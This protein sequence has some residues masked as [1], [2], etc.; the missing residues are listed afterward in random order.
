M[1]KNTCA[2]ANMP[3]QH[4]HTHTHAWK[5]PNMHPS[6]CFSELQVQCPAAAPAMHARGL[7][8]FHP[9]PPFRGGAIKAYGEHNSERRWERSTMEE[10]KGRR[11]RSEVVQSREERIKD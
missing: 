2:H 10:R 4:T 7:N 8:H 11:G 5:F 3:A 9:H 1:R 6:A